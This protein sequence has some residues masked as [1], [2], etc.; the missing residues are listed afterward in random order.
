MKISTCGVYNV[1]LRVGVWKM[2]MLRI[3]KQKLFDMEGHSGQNCKLIATCIPLDR[4]CV[5]LD[6]TSIPLDRSFLPFDRTLII[7]LR[8]TLHWFIPP[9]HFTFIRTA[10]DTSFQRGRL[11]L[12]L[13]FVWR[14]TT[15][16]YMT[17]N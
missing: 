10:V 1:K 6:R 17:C 2:R 4:I 13:V 15:Y 16:D 8:A 11:N 5:P 12:D 3:F 14:H 7:L 9:W